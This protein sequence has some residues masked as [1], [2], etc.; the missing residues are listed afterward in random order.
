[1]QFLAILAAAPIILLFCSFAVFDTRITGRLAII[2]TWAQVVVTVI[3]LSPLVHADCTRLVITHGI[4]LD[5]ISAS[6]LLLTTIVIASATTQAALFFEREQQVNIEVRPQHVRLLYAASAIL[7]LAM[8]LVFMCNNLGLLWITVETST[9]FSAPLVY[10]QRTKNA[11]EATWKYLIICSVAIAFALLGT[12][13]I[14]ASSQHGNGTVGSLNLSILTAEAPQ[15]HY[16]L[17][18]LGFIFCLLGYGTKAGIFPLHSWLPDAYSEAPAPYSAVLS[19]ALSNCALYAI[20]KVVQVVLASGH[21]LLVYSMV[22]GLGAIT[23]VAAGLFLIR[24]T[25]FKRLWAYSSMENTGIMMVAIGLGSAPLFLLQAVNHAL[26]KVAAFL[27][28]GNITQAAGTMNLH[29]LRGVMRAAPLWAVLLTFATFA[30]TGAPPFGAFL[31]ETA[32]LSAAA[33]TQHWLVA[34]VLV[35][36]LMLCFIAICLHIGRVVFGTPQAKFVAYRPYA[37]SIVPAVLIL[38]CLVLGLSF[39]SNFWRFMVE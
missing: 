14:F 8:S 38:G 30:V 27:L 6:F 34:A 25:G 15:L 11:L 17:L 24:Q 10:F 28:A 20:W 35:V 9:L 39:N 3:L 33:D 36:A 21:T 19:G 7:L 13:F 4:L 23:V 37:S 2:I 5:R 29:E 32:I 16:A 12:I 22:G 31:S 1:M 26:A 18:R